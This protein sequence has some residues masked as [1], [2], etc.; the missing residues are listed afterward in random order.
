MKNKKPE[1]L[2]PAG[3]LERLKVAF[4][5]GADAV[6]LGGREFSLR[7][8]ATNFSIEEIKEACILAHQMGKKVYVTVNIIFHNEDYQ[9]LE[10]YLKKLEECRVDAI[11]VADLFIL[12][13]VKKLNL[14]LPVHISTQASTLN[15]EAALF[16]KELGAER[17]VLGRELSKQ[18]IEKIIEETGLEVECFIHGAMC[19][20]YSGRCVLSN[21]FTGRDANRGGCS[22]ICRF[23][24]DLLDK[25]KNPILSDTKFTMSC[26]DL[27]MASYIPQ[28]MNI[29]V[30]SFKIEG[31]M[32]SNYYIASVVDCYRH[33]IDDYYDGTL[34]EEKTSYYQKVLDN[35]A[36]RESIPQFFDGPVDVR[37]QYYLGREERSNQD[38]LGIV[39]NY[40]EKTQMVTITERNYFKKG[41]EVE[42]FGPKKEP[43]SFIVPDLYDEKGSLLEVAR[44]PEEII[45]FHLSHKVEKDDLMRK[46]IK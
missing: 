4:H 1:L 34:T 46:K 18:E 12:S 28:M 24:F 35:V 2:S 31:R 43:I 22:Q 17:V 26:K 41:D 39:L 9:E 27:S 15:K 16:L 42:I 11:I 25:K 40:D 29:G 3:S 45:C 8:N 37:H 14:K 30:S 33:I 44:H 32:R 36:N 38:F 23:E 6:Y 10:N 13:L 21:F 5:Y 20:G 7:A 19:A